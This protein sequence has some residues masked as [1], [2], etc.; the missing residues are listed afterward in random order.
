[1]A[2][3]LGD[4]TKYFYAGLRE[5]N[6]RDKQELRSLIGSNSNLDLDNIMK[7]I[8][9]D[10][11]AKI[12]ITGIESSNISTEEK[13]AEWGRMLLYLQSE[14]MAHGTDVSIL[15]AQHNNELI[16]F[17]ER[18][19]VQSTTALS[20]L[21]QEIGYE[22]SP[23]NI[24]E[25]QELTNLSKSFL[26][27]NGIMRFVHKD[28]IR[29]FLQ[30]A[31][32]V[33]EQQEN[34]ATEDTYEDAKG[35][36]ITQLDALDF[37]LTTNLRSMVHE[38][39]LEK[40]QPYA[41][42]LLNLVNQTTYEFPKGSPIRIGLVWDKESYEQGIG[43]EDIVT[44]FEIL[45]EEVSSLNPL[46]QTALVIYRLNDMGKRK[47]FS[48]GEYLQALSETLFLYKEIDQLTGGFYQREEPLRLLQEELPSMI[49]ESGYRRV[50]IGLE[51]ISDRAILDDELQLILNKIRNNPEISDALQ[52]FYTT[53]GQQ[54]FVYVD[55]EDLNNE[56]ND[57]IWRSVPRFI[58]EKGYKLLE[59]LID[60]SI[61]EKIKERKRQELYEAMESDKNLNK[62]AEVF[63]QTTEGT[64]VYVAP[65]NLEFVT[66]YLK[67][68][69]KEYTLPK[70]EKIR[71]QRERQEALLTDLMQHRKDGN[72]ESAQEI[73]AGLNNLGFNHWSLD[74]LVASTRVRQFSQ[75]ENY[76]K[77]N[78]NNKRL[79][80]EIRNY[81]V[82]LTPIK[83]IP[84]EIIG[85][86]EEDIASIR[87]F[88]DDIQK[89][90][91]KYNKQSK[92]V[93][94]EAK[95][96][97]DAIITLSR[98][99]TIASY[100]IGIFNKDYRWE[101]TRKAIKAQ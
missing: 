57:V 81:T 18:N 23:E 51:D 78:Y 92:E 75:I 97:G 50:S 65:H 95:Y 60:N 85:A 86:V 2:I 16:K 98:T 17:I 89:Q 28:Y 59:S 58:D 67:K 48:R 56:F 5:N 26:T 93:R 41:T 94:Q 49:R 83:K 35:L 19:Y 7:E 87:T 11:T 37:K 24:L 9:L 69:V 101:M 44:K 90:G 46:Q 25:N 61:P 34:T 52:Q 77:G 32:H 3:N 62:Y 13:L 22:E 76:V 14:N 82:L 84:R 21:A 40:I 36:E 20:E 99:Q 63:E 10:R 68:F 88:A 47:R 55:D 100:V 53:E 4:F 8:G 29:D 74:L 79:R 66:N 12:M 96:L 80:E 42:R 33:I 72:Y 45:P 15:L 64:F 54:F 27:L 30:T 38:G 39:T 73:K 31:V 43:L 1:M 91:R 70:K 6:I 71:L